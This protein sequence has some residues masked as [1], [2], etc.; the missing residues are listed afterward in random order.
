L[1]F[2]C[3]PATVCP[4]SIVF[5]LN[6]LVPLAFGSIAFHYVTIQN[7][8]PRDENALSST[9]D[10]SE[11]DASYFLSRLAAAREGTA[12]QQA[13]L[14]YSF[15]SYLRAVAINN[16][17]ADANGKLSASDLV[18]CALID[19]CDGFDQ[20]RAG[21]KDEFKAWLRQILMN[22]IANR[23]RFLRRQKRDV[24][25]EVNI[26]TDSP[27]APDS[28]SPEAVALRREDEK[29]LE[30]AV[31]Q[32]SPDYA[33]VI[34]LRHREKLSFREIGQK[35]NRSADAARMLWNRA[36]EELTQKMAKADSESSASQCERERENK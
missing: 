21:G 22:G 19:A 30:E 11:D 7:R 5:H 8:I 12:E 17:G 26:A 31:E 2:W 34:R 4:K 25:K 1:P 23:Y 20:C 28:E 13:E 18:Q 10:S 3:R 29:R 27:A 6:A 32:L 33:A 9:S 14:L 15:H 36:L 16:I 35:T 24:G